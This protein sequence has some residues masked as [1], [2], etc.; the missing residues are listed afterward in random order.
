MSWALQWFPSR[1]ALHCGAGR[2]YDSQWARDESWSDP[3]RAPSITEW[4]KFLSSWHYQRSLSHP[5]ARSKN[6]PGPPP[7]IWEFCEGYDLPVPDFA[8]EN[9]QRHGWTDKLTI[10]AKQA[11]RHAYLQSLTS[12]SRLRL[13]KMQR[14]MERLKH[15][16]EMASKATRTHHRA[17]GIGTGCC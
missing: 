8:I 16:R 15:D 5:E 13:F 10:A 9:A 2:L 1:L 4:L 11:E 14:Y 6:W 7:T 3:P 12:E 17:V